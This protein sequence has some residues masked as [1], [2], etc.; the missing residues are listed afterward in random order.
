MSEYKGPPAADPG[1]LG[2]GASRGG[3][4][5]LVAQSGLRNERRGSAAVGADSR[6]S[7]VGG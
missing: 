7:R 5:M 1:A 6:R 2:V 3:S 4:A